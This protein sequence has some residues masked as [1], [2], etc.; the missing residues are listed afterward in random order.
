M[1]QAE[2]QMFFLF[3]WKLRR[4]WVWGAREKLWNES[5]IYDENDLDWNEH[6]YDRFHLQVRI[7]LLNFFMSA[8]LGEQGACVCALLPRRF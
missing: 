8:K 1:S 2:Q 6:F 4:V 5:N 7:V 3:R